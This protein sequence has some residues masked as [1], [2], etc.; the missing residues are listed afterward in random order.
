MS[1]HF[2]HIC[3]FAYKLHT[4][5]SKD[6][7]EATRQ[8][9]FLDT[10]MDG[11]VEIVARG[12]MERQDQE[13][14][15]LQIAQEAFD[16]GLAL[17]IQ[18]DFDSAM[19]EFQRSLEIREDV[20]GR[21]DPGTAKCYQWVGTIFFH[22]EDYERALDNFS[23]CFRIQNEQL[24]SDKKS[25]ARGIVASWINKAL[26]AKGMSKSSE[27]ALYWRNM[28]SCIEHEQR[29]DT[30]HKQEKYDRAI[31]SYQTALQLEH[32]RR[33]MS[34]STPSRPLVDAADL[35]YKIG[36][37]NKS[38]G[39][40]HR[41]MM[42]FR[43]AYGIY[44]TFGLDTRYTQQTY[45]HMV[46]AAF[47]MGFRYSVVSDY[48]QSIDTSIR[49]ERT[50][51]WMVE[52]D[53]EQALKSYQAAIAIEENCVGMLQGTSALLYFKVGKVYNLLGDKDK[54]LVYVCRALGI[55]ELI[56]GPQHRYTTST[57]KLIRSMTKS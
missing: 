6:E 26:E 49:N 24:T 57:I 4:F 28:M 53:C 20:C 52:R 19:R 50:G 32:S 35:Y 23:R 25:D 3:F 43:Q 47:D 38:L 9:E 5:R 34:S 56:L 13:E 14:F 46:D 7:I 48:M 30:R 11:A 27:K 33:N 21:S 2:S 8:L 54:A 31:E 29:G 37:C 40:C 39:F 44:S 10:E 15:Q 55:F 12:T 17:W 22:Q 16:K 36:R 41:A 1:S 51:D 45:D 42:A 18:S